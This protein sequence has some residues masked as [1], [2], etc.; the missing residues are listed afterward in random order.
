[1]NNAREALI[2]EALGEL[3]VLLDRAEAVVP[4][5]DAA[6]KAAEQASAG[7]AAQAGALDASV[8]NLMGNAKAQAIR[9][10][11]RRTDELART[12]GEAQTR[13]MKAAAQQLFREELLPAFQR[14]A[15][16]LDDRDRQHRWRS[17]WVHAATAAAASAITWCIAACALPSH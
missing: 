5:L 2:V 14:L 13:S 3:A 17:W 6:A 15:R 4:A 10:V 9:H 11:A 16:S 1:M 12:A 8:A 7:L